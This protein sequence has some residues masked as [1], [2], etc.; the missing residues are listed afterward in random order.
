MK[1]GAGKSGACEFNTIAYLFAILSWL[2][3]ENPEIS[4]RVG[5]TQAIVPDELTGDG[6]VEQLS[7][8]GADRFLHLESLA[9]ACSERSKPGKLD[10]VSCL[11]V[12]IKM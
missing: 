8:Q 6:Q 2:T 9:A 11:S 1:T 3:V 12:V 7:I 5:L 10:S 4:F